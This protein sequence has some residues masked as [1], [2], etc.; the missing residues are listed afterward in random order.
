LRDATFGRNLSSGRGAVTKFYLGVVKLLHS[1]R[2]YSLR[3]ERYASMI[4]DFAG[5]SF[6]RGGFV[7]D[8][9]CGPGGITALLGGVHHL[10]GVD[11][12]RYYLLRFVEPSVQRIQARAEHLPLKTGSL[13]TI[14][15]ISLVEH[16]ADHV[17]FFRELARVLGPDGHVVLQLPEL[18]FPIEPHTK[19]PFLYVLNPSRQARI[20][21]A[22]GYGDLNMDTSLERVIW[23][24]KEAGLQVDRV[25]PLWHF[26]L[27]RLVG[28]PMGYFALFKKVTSP[29]ETPKDP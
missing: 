22:T 14:V 16:V 17:A 27:A 26:R 15:A 2:F 3:N 23:S 25:A 18:R 21:A 7:V 29:L 28:V 20:L 8:L 11:S 13:S 9:G 19:W 12:D 5:L 24:A 6:R 1:F 10:I 4:R